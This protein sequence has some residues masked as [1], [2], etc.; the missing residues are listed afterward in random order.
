MLLSSTMSML[1]MYNGPIKSDRRVGE[2][3][4]TDGSEILFIEAVACMSVST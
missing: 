3:R 1:E 2:R 4:I